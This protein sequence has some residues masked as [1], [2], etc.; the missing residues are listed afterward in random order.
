M[1][2]RTVCFRQSDGRKWINL[3]ISVDSPMQKLDGQDVEIKIVLWQDTENG[4]LR[5]Q[6]E[7]TSWKRELTLN[8]EC[9]E[10]GVESLV[11]VEL[12]DETDQ[13]TIG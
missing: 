12:I 8:I 7:T 9:D 5:L 3:P 4:E 2:E 10:D 11:G 1:T 13:F 6:L